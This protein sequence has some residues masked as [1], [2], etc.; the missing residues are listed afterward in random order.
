ELRV[1]GRP[2]TRTAA[3]ATEWAIVLEQQVTVGVDAVDRPILHGALAARDG[4]NEPGLVRADVAE[5]LEFL[6]DNVGLVR[7]EPV[8][9][10]RVRDAGTGGDDASDEQAGEQFPSPVRSWRRL[11]RLRSF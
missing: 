8:S 3:T 2:G 11:E 7:V 5:R 10:D 6:V 9:D 4:R 1:D